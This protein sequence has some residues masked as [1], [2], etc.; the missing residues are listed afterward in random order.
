MLA[1]VL[2]LIDIIMRD[3]WQVKH[4]PKFGWILLV[5]VLPAIGTVLWFL[6]GRST[7]ARRRPRGSADSSPRARG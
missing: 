1:T 2:A 7:A 3:D 6:L 5:I 4:L